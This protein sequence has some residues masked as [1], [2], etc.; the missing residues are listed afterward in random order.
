GP[1]SI[2]LVAA[3]F[4]AGLFIDKLTGADD[5]AGKAAKSTYDFTVVLDTRMMSITKFS[6]AIDKLNESTRG[7][8]DTQAL[9]VDSSLTSTKAGVADAERRLA[10]VD[11]QLKALGTGPSG[12][13]SVVP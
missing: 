7:L 11:R 13:L 1:L 12:P 9:L 3:S 2:A 4:V 5:A 6:E 10:E 8:I